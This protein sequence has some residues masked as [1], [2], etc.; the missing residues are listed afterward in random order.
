MDITEKN[1]R[2]GMQNIYAKSVN[3]LMTKMFPYKTVIPEA[4]PKTNKMVTTK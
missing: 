2:F 4:N 1:L 3:I